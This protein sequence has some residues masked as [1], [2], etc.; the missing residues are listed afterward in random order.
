MS[1][2]SFNRSPILQVLTVLFPNV[3]FPATGGPCSARS[4]VTMRFQVALFSTAVPR[5]PL[6]I[7]PR[8]R[9]IF[10]NKEGRCLSNPLDPGGRDAPGKHPSRTCVPYN[11]LSWTFPP[12]MVPGCGARPTWTCTCWCRQRDKGGQGCCG[13]RGCG[14]AQCPSSKITPGDSPLKPRGTLPW[15]FSWLHS[16]FNSLRLQT[17]GGYPGVA[18]AGTEAAV[19]A[20]G[21]GSAGPSRG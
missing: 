4:P 20:G 15:P 2:T 12:A 17:R 10:Q 13:R 21:R 1:A 6:A 16:R 8:E 19:P 7:V 14:R 18:R 11:G 5:V 9:G 3:R